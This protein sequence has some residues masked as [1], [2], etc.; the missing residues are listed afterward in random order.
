MAAPIETRTCKEGKSNHKQNNEAQLD[1]S[2]PSFNPLLSLYSDS[3][4][5]PCPDVKPVDNVAR[6][7]STLNQVSKENVKE[8]KKSAKES[9]S[10]KLADAKTISSSKMTP[11]E[12]LRALRSGIPIQP[13]QKI[14]NDSNQTGERKHKRYRNVLNTMEGNNMN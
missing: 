13:N 3:V 4:K 11:M 6:L 10:E 2:S 8:T 5:I 14:D 12:R 9:N 7:E 1:L